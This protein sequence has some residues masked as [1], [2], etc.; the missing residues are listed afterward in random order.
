MGR[1]TNVKK[2]LLFLLLLFLSLGVALR[3]GY[4]LV[5]GSSVLVA[6]SYAAPA[7]ADP[8]AGLTLT[9]AGDLMSHTVNFRM[10]DFDAV[11]ADVAPLLRAD[12]LS[13]VNLE[14]PVDSSRPYASY[15]RFNVHPEY[16]DS[17][18]NAGFDVLSAA[19]NHTADWHRD[20][21]LA[22]MRYLDSVAERHGITWSGIRG[23]P[24]RDFEI[25]TIERNGYRVGF[26]AITQFSN[27][28]REYAGLEYVYLLSFRARSRVEA[29]LEWL[30]AHTAAY[31]LFVLSYHGGIEYA[32]T[33]DP[34]K[35]RFFR[36]LVNAGVDIVW[37]HHPHVLQPW[38]RVVRADGTEALV[39][40]STGN[41]VSGQ[42]HRLG[43][44]QWS[45][46]RAHTG[47]SALYQVRVDR[48]AERIE[49]HLTVIPI[50][51]RR[52]ADGVRVRTS[53]SLNGG[54]A[55][56]DGQRRRLSAPQRVAVG[57]DWFFE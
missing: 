28:W 15:P 50:F 43:A 56:Y 25:Q 20:G 19:N 21:I 33:A 41:F 47:D 16:V 57:P 44:D 8:D 39:F 42:P 24:G 22:T 10:R 18:I 9:F 31:D 2:S 12:D 4:E 51:H 1:Q 53:P 55:T 27:E 11:Y 36:R 37:A 29:F 40:P 30:E 7:A 52:E 14:F 6:D 54:W 23:S 3:S 49:L 45:V 34:A 35:M 46:A 17:A 32:L 26:L 5:I 13:F 38:E 48:A